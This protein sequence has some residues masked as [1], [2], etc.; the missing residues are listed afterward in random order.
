MI[1]A[2]FH[3]RVTQNYLLNIVPTLNQSLPKEEENEYRI[4]AKLRQAQLQII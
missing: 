4:P 2:D 1:I 3:E